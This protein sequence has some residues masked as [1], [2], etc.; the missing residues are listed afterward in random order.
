MK[1]RNRFCPSARQRSLL[2]GAITL[3]FI[4][5]LS[6]CNSMAGMPTFIQPPQFSTITLTPQATAVR[7][8]LTIVAPGSGNHGA[9]GVHIDTTAFPAGTLEVEV[10]VDPASATDGSFYLYPK[11]VQLPFQGPIRNSLDIKADVRRGSIARMRYRFVG[12]R[13]Y[14]FFAEG[15]WFSP[16]GAA[17][18]IHAQV[19]VTP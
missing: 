10:Q 5:T 2:G 17:G 9:G 8:D 12:G 3:L 18:A 11:G 13:V 1:L 4:A 19:M 14:T 16:R 15:N 7:F 6:G